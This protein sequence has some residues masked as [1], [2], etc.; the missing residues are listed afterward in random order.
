MSWEELGQVGMSRD[1]LGQ[2]GTSWDELGQVRT[3]W[4]P[5]KFQN[6]DIKKMS[7]EERKKK[8]LGYRVTLNER[9]LKKQNGILILLFE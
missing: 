9:Q 1:E 8:N 7:P 6:F 4:E 2:V 3:S 5:K